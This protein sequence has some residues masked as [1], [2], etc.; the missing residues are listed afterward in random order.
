MKPRL[1]IGLAIALTLGQLAGTY[2]FYSQMQ[3]LSGDLASVQQLALEA[4]TR[5]SIAGGHA[6]DLEVKYEHD[7]E[8]L[9]AI[10]GELSALRLAVAKCLH[11]RIRIPTSVGE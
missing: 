9:R 8:T 4:D 6:A 5:S 3:R 11:R 7:F 2:Y 1:R 10:N